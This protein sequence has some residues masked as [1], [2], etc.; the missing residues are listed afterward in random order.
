MAR[1]WAEAMIRR[2]ANA[3]AAAH[4]I[5]AMFRSAY[6]ELAKPETM[7]LEA[8]TRWQAA[9]KA[10]ILPDEAA[11]DAARLLKALVFRADGAPR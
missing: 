3:G 10:M 5:G 9:R 11:V 7:A 2:T 4:A 8:T 1:F 6:A